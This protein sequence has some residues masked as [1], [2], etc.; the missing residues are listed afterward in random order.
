MRKT[1]KYRG[2]KFTVLGQIG[3]SV[4]GAAINYVKF[5]KCLEE[6]FN[7]Y[8]GTYN[9]N[10]FYKK[11]DGE[12]DIF[13][14]EGFDKPVIPM[15]N[16]FMIWEGETK[17]Y[18]G[19]KEK[20]IIQNLKQTDVSQLKE[21]GYTAT[22]IEE[23]DKIMNY[24]DFETSRGKKISMTTARRMLGTTEFLSGMSRAA[25]HWDSSR[26]CANGKGSVSFNCRRWYK[27]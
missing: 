18:N 6:M 23:I 8:K 27:P 21:W 26:E 24:T 12:A 25:F 11:H 14:L 1:F 7:K 17:P 10:K 20:V 15:E 3:D 4:R 2:H 9:H 16:T 22:D 19:I 13:K 5:D